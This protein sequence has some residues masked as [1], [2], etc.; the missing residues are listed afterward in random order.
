[1]SCRFK[2]AVAA[3]ILG[4]GT[5]GFAAAEPFEDG[6]DA[7]TRGDYATA[8][9]LWRPLA[10]QGGAIAHYNLGLMYYRGE[11]VPQNYASALI[12]FRKAADQEHA[13]AQ[14]SLGHMYFEG[15]GIPQNSAAA[16]IWFRKAA[17]QGDARAQTGLGFMCT[18]TARVSRRTIRLRRVGIERPPTRA[19][20]PLNT[21]SGPCTSTARTMSAHTCDSTWRPLVAAK[22]SPAQIAA[23]Q[24]LAREWK[25]ASTP[26]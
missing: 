9:R 1:M 13:A 18:P 25:P 5:A 17:D 15:R 8:M 2:V 14:Y 11:G 22:M 7:V 21:I 10:E 6:Y 3:L 20:S 24:R 12:W 16:A 26:R 23:A 4:V 19:T